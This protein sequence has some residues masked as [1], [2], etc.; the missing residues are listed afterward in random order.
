MC[1]NKCGTKS[2]PSM[3]SKPVFKSSSNTSTIDMAQFDRAATSRFRAHPR[4]EFFPQEWLEEVEHNVEYDR[5]VND[6]NS[7]DSRRYSV[8]KT[9]KTMLFKKK[10]ALKM[11][12]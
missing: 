5:L 8:L 7:L 6:M 3:G 2:G 12:I 9:Y 4:L 1:R 11:L 10:L